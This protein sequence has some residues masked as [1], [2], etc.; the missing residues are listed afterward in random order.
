M[1]KFAGQMNKYNSI[2]IFLVLVGILF[3]SCSAERKQMRKYLL[4][5]TLAQKDSAAFYFYERGDYEKANFLFEELMGRYR[6]KP[7]YENIIYHYAW[8]KFKQSYYI[9][10]SHYF[11]QYAKQF[12]TS[13]RAEECAFQQAYCYYM[14]SA[15][16]YLDQGYT[17]KAIDQFQYFLVAYPESERVKEAN[18][19]I[20]SL[21]ERLAKKA[22]EQARLYFNMSNFKGAVTSF[23]V[24]IQEFPDSRYQEEA[25]LMLF[26]SMVGLA[27]NSTER[28]K[29]NRYLDAIE[30]YERFVD[31][32]PN[33]PYIKEAESLYVKAKRGLGRLKADEAEQSSEE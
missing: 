30:T 14:E 27:E 4:K 12:P 29:E 15:P 13:P 17:A 2:A 11:E 28:R 22:F 7:E 9:I 20:T 10:A 32:F 26:K 1:L 33:S 3:A 23:E 31:R 16:Y 19:I 18:D 21:R 5:G 8:S 24:M 25:N 6:G